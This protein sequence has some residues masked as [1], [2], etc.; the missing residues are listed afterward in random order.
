MPR[1]RN[2][3]SPSSK[4]PYKLSRSRLDSDDILHYQKMVVALVETR[5]LMGEVDK[6]IVNF[7]IK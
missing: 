2:I 6:A 3:Y 7:P 4:E 1:T 5:R